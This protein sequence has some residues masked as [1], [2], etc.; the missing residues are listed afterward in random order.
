MCLSEDAN[1]TKSDVKE[2]V[3]ILEDVVRRMRRVLGNSHPVAKETSR[4]LEIS[5]RRLANFKPK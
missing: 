3:A 2:A 5:R 4:T 1:A